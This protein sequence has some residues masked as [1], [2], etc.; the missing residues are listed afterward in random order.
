[1]ARNLSNNLLD[2]WLS[3]DHLPTQTIRSLIEE[4]HD[5]RNRL[6]RSETDWIECAS[7]IGDYDF[8]I[9]RAQVLPWPDY[10]LR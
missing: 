4:I 5:L 1:M 10:P 3:A 2:L 7:L 8:P 6:R 9:I